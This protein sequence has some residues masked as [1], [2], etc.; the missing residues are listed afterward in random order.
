MRVLWTHNFNPDIP[1]AGVFMHL[2]ADGVRRLGVDL[3][4]EYLG[5]LRAPNDSL[6]AVKRLKRIAPEFDII[7]AQ[8]GSA[9]SWVTS[10]VNEVPIIVTL[11]GSDWNVYS[12]AINFYY[13]HTRMARFLTFRSLKKYDHIICVSER[14]GNE[15]EK[16]FPGKRISIIPDPINLEVFYPKNKDHVR[17]RLGYKNNKERWVLFNST[18][19]SKPVKRYKLAS[20]A[21]EL[22]QKEVEGLR[23]RVANN[24]PHKDIP[25][26]VS[27][28]EMILCTSTAEGWPNSVKEALACN[29]P[30]VSTNVSDLSKIADQEVSCQVCP[31]DARLLAK[32][33][34]E[35]L[36]MPANYNLRRHVKN[37]NMEDSSERL[38]G[39]YKDIIS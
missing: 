7:H 27:A 14:M 28:C 16:Y 17:E 5:N 3:Q 8:F 15:I 39:I 35:T 31:P 18:S 24:L 25:D 38:Y 11:R 10:F 23:L 26:F 37:M 22:A 33:I 29:I 1:N 21:I 30:F 13:L 20:E 36:S 19:L 12:D 2:F 9:C 6:R 4:Y 34:C 32:A